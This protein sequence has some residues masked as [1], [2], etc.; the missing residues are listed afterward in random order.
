MFA[1]YEFVDLAGV[2]CV[3]V[4]VCYLYTTCISLTNTKVSTGWIWTGTR[5]LIV[6]VLLFVGL[7]L[8]G[9]I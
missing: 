9:V 5:Y 4:G 7:N 2:W 1:G 6:S 3:V 8:L